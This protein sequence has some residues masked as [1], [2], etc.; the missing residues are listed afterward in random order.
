MALYMYVKAPPS[1]YPR[2]SRFLKQVE[3]LVP[4]ILVTLGSLLV[5]NV[6]W[7]IINY[8]FFVTPQL[9]H[10]KLVSPINEDRTAFFS[11]LASTQQPIFSDQA[12]QALGKEI[13]YTNASNWFPTVD[14]QESHQSKIT[15]YTIDIPAV[16]VE[17]AVVA[18]GGEDLS[19]SLIQYPGTSNP[20][21]PGSPVLFGHSILRQFY[22]PAVNNPR[23]YISIFSKIMTLEEG[24]EIFVDFDGIRYKY[25]VADKVVVEPEDVFILQQRHDHHE[26]KLITCVPEGTYLHRGV[27][28][29]ELQDINN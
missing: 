15:H 8:H 3:K 29:A 18:I 23:R 21:Q 13:D 2:R 9:K 7:P 27:V 20:G 6:S 4:P 11:P 16:N 5:A 26:L 28:I 1:K 12:A 24:D 25:T 19:D 10:T 22:N 14:Y 17:E